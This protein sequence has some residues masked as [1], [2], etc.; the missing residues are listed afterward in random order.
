MSN[1]TYRA[2]YVDG[3]PVAGKIEERNFSGTTRRAPDSASLG[4]VGSVAEAACKQSGRETRVLRDDN[5]V[6]QVYHP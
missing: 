2:I 6:A 3:S 5:T 1:Y 4:E